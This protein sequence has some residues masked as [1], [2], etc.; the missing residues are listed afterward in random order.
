M[1]EYS[2]I[3]RSVSRVDAL[4]KVTGDANYVGDMVLPGM[5]CGKILRSK[6]P[7]AKILNVDVTKAQRL[8][9]VRAIIT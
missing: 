2:I 8:P 6:H 7:H 5:L 1:E 3:G 4:A 9:G